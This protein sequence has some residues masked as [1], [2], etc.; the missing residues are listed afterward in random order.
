MNELDAIRAALQRERMARKQAEAIIEEKSRELYDANSQ[1]KEW[2]ATL[3]ARIVE[4][5]AA[6]EHQKQELLEAKN[7][8]ELATKAKTAFLSKVSHELRTPLNAI[9]GFT[10]LLMEN[11]A[12]PDSRNFLESIGFSAR[13]LLDTINDVLD[14][15]QIES[16]ALVIQKGP[17]S[18]KELIVD[19]R[20]NWELILKEKGVAFMFRVS[21]SVPDRVVGDSAKITQIL[22]N[23]LGNATKFTD[24]GFVSLHID[25]NSNNPDLLTFSIEDTGI[26]IPEDQRHRLFESFSQLHDSRQRSFGG[27][28]LGLSITKQLAEAMGGS[29]TMQPGREKGS[30][31]TVMLPLSPVIQT[32]KTPVTTT[33]GTALRQFP[34]C[35][36]LVVD[37]VDLNVK[38]LGHVLKRH[39]LE[40]TQA[41]SGHEA[42]AYAIQTPF[43]L[44]FMDLQMPGMDGEE[45]AAEIR[46]TGRNMPIVALTADVFPATRDRVLK[47]GMNGFL[48]KPVDIARLSVTLAEFLN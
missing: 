15:S 23:L 42:L 43:D 37:D 12:S 45:T 6:L 41:F 7:A 46:R 28:G 44:I 11:P 20:R 33:A 9:I 35:K 8:A 16:G 19:L 40:V 2:N 14:L 30:I 26:G 22:N 21:D 17:F 36:V 32:A 10:Q 39:G 24:T 27:T 47:S 18:L 1:L 25:R 5:T 13:N 48:S 4:R 3:E 38:M 34:G 31:F 29:I